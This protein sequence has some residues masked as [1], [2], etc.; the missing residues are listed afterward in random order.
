LKAVQLHEGFLKRFP[1][2]LSGGEK[3]RVAI[4]R[5]FAF[6]PACVVLDEPTSALDVS[7][8]ASILNL[9][10][11][12]QERYGTSYLFISHDLGVV[13]H[14]AD[15]IGVMYLGKLCEVGRTEEIFSP[16][17]HPYTRALLSA[18]PVL[19]PTRQH[20]PIRLE[21]PVPSARTLPT[22]CPFHTR[23]PQ[24]IGPICEQVV[25]PLVQVTDTHALAC[26]IPLAEL[27]REEPIL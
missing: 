24:K 3:Q 5:A 2:E 15:R 17:Y 26:H 10:L 7:I 25:P 14:V 9:L 16:P 19:D 1:A 22:G 20:K 8:Q 13:R 27:S 12:L 4:A 6:Q 21:G 23:C 18:I 11:A